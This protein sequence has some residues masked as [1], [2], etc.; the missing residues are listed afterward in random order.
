MRNAEDRFYSTFVR[1]LSE[2]KHCQFVSRVWKAPVI[3][4]RV[5][6]I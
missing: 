6:P 5:P 4:S 1:G 2:E 3:I